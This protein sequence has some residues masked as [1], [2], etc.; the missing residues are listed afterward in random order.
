MQWEIQ[1]EAERIVN[2]QLKAYVSE[3]ERRLKLYALHLLD[4][5]LVALLSSNEC[6]LNLIEYQRKCLQ[7]RTIT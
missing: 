4:R 5:L 6:T 1:E 2:E 7:N 3:Q